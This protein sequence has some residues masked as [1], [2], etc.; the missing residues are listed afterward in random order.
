MSK[1]WKVILS[2]IIIIVIIGVVATLCA[3]KP[4]VAVTGTRLNA[5][6]G[7]GDIPTLDPALASDTSSIQVDM[8]VFVGLTRLDEVT[9][10]V[11]PGMATEWKTSS[12]GAVYTFTI[13]D[14]V[15]WVKYDVDKGKVVEVKDGNKVRK[16]NAHDFYYGFMRTLDPETAGPYVYLLNDVIKGA[17]EYNGGEVTDPESVGI[18]VIDDYT[19][20]ITFNVAATYDAAI[21]GMWMG[22]AAPQWL[23][24]EEGDRWTEGGVIQTYGPYAVKEWIHDAEL[25]M[26]ANPFWPGTDSI[27]QAKIEEINFKFLDD[28]PS[29][30]EY[31]AGNIDVSPAPLSDIDRI[32]ADPVLSKEFTISPYFCSYYY[33][34][35][36]TKPFVD[37]MRVRRALSMAIDRQSLIDNV[38]KGEQIP[39]RWVENPGLAGAPTLEEYPDLGVKYDPEAAKASLQEYLDEK[40]LKAEDLVI[41]LMHNTSEAHAAIATA[42]QAMWK[43]TLGIDVTVTNQEWKVYLATT[44]GADTPQVFRLGWCL[45]YPDANNFTKDLFAVGANSN[46]RN[47]DGTMGGISWENEEYERLL[48]EAQVEPDNDKRTELYAKAANILVWEDAVVAPIYWYSRLQITKPYVTRT[49]ATGGQELYEKWSIDMS[50]KP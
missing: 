38:T 5:R 16:V 6:L 22:Y 8:E 1:K 31:E 41:E 4:S 43:E 10:V 2:I 39:S 3:K 50:A 24:E 20:E 19:L 46:A 14:D 42:I 33:G 49:F 48:K 34:F 32:K 21:A 40:E 36:T 35:N 28:S 7:P 25:T 12:D 26:V 29:L 37:D 11:Q 17:A 44:D 15:S 30:A 47:E 9:N 18:K 23:I 45:D 13:R 27:P